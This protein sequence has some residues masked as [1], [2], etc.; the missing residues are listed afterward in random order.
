MILSFVVVVGGGF[1]S[2][3][4]FSSTSG[5]SF[6]DDLIRTFGNFGPSLDFAC[7]LVLDARGFFLPVAAAFLP[8]VA[9]G[10]LPEEAAGTE[11]WSPDSPP[12]AP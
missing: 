9:A 1:V 11:G 7:V 12:A 6:D 4:A 8:V 3:S 2:G 10:F 5:T